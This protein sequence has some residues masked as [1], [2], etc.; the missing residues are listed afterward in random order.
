MIIIRNFPAIDKS[1]FRNNYKKT[2]APGHFVHRAG[3]DRMGANDRK[4]DQKV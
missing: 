2:P 4:R 1:Q 3:A